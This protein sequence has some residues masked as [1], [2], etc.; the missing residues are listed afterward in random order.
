LPSAARNPFYS[1]R[2]SSPRYSSLRKAGYLQAFADDISGACPAACI[3]EF[4]TGVEEILAGAQ[5]TLV[6]RKCHLYGRLAHTI[7]NPIF[8]VRTEGIRKIVGCPVGPPDFRR[9]QITDLLDKMVSSLNALK[10]YSPPAAFLFISKCINARANFICRVTELPDAA[11]IFEPFD[12]AID[13]ALGALA[14][15]PIDLQAQI[16]TLRRL[17]R[18]MRGPGIYDTQRTTRPQGEEP[19]ASPYLRG[20]TDPLSLYSIPS[21]SC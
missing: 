11:A 6:P 21:D 12:L 7:P 17:P 20:Y 1:S 18:K 5:L 8:P 13:T 15:C 3:P 19:F 10:N 2:P 4:S 16:R 9:A 14:D